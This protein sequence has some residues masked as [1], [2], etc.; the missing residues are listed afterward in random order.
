MIPVP[1]SLNMLNLCKVAGKRHLTRHQPSWP[2]WPQNSRRQRRRLHF[3]P[4][5]HREV[6][7]AVPAVDLSQLYAVP[8]LSS[9]AS[10]TNPTP[11]GYAPS[12]IAQAYGFSGITFS[13]GVK[14]DGTGQTIAIV[15]A[16]N[17]PNIASDLH[18]FDQ[19]FGLADPPKFSV[20]NQNGGSALPATSAGWSEEIALDVEWAHAMA[21]GANI[22]LV[23]ANSSSLS[24]LLA[25]VDYARNAA[26]VSVVSMSWGS[27][28]FFSETQ[29]DRYFT[30]PS[31]H[32][33]VTFVASAGDS[34]AQAEWPAISPNVL[35]VGGTA[36][37]VSG[38]S[39][40]SESG[41]SGSGGGYSNYV[42]EPS[43]QSGVQSSGRRTGPDVSYDASPN[44]GF[45]VYDTVAV[46]GRT[47]WFQIGG[48]SAGAPQW[49]ALIAIADQ[50][51]AL[52]GQDTLGGAQSLVYKLS[53]SDFH[54]VTS[55]SNGYAATAGYDLVTGRGTPVASSVIRDLVGNNLVTSTGSTNQSNSGTTSTS[56]QTTTTTTYEWVYWHHRWWLV[57]V[58][59]PAAMAATDTAAINAGM[60]DVAVGISNNSSVASTVPVASTTPSTDAASS[61]APSNSTTAASAQTLLLAPQ[62]T[63][64]SGVIARATP[65]PASGG[66]QSGGD[67]GGGDDDES[68]KDQSSDRNATADDVASIVTATAKVSV[69][70]PEFK[71]GLVESARD[72][73]FAA[74]AW[75]CAL[76]ETAEGVLDSLSGSRGLNLAGLA[77]ALAVG[78]RSTI[79]ASEG[80]A[81]LTLRTRSK[82]RCLSRELPFR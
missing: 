16:Y 9:L 34:G 15:D 60:V 37:R 61:R 39:Y 10:V 58:T 23:E 43:Y 77:L 79:G 75:V 31:G 45:A 24:D 59:S 62:T 64:G 63:G 3:E 25:G 4:L 17:D 26:G 82:S 49:S 46:N 21:P 54:D 1:E 41:W 20:V 57:I 50:G 18:V 69:E 68:Q 47:G 44:T 55:G 71:T 8:T 29:Y 65:T 76:D 13:G 14:G 32:N 19:T 73:C 51:R 6:L 48:T 40:A 53:S 11:T 36:L 52:S 5:E 80:T 74:D 22:L 78:T 81:Q 30:T 27:S 12:Q 66:G 38:S 28:E 56:T 33:S 42:T 7:S 35:S 70:L 67:S 72:A 2:L